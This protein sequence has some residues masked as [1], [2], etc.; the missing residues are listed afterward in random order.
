LSIELIVVL[1]IAALLILLVLGTPVGFALGFSG[2]LGLFLLDGFDVARSTLGRAPYNT[3]ARFVLTVIPMFILMG[4][5]ARHARVAEN[6]F[7]VLSWWLRRVPGGLAIA[8]IM[9]CAGFAAVTGSSLATI[10]AVGQMA[11]REMQ[12]YGYSPAVSAGVVGAAG[13][14]GVLIPP[15]IP[16]VI[17]A[18]LARE[19]IAALLLAGVIPGVIS[20]V[21]YAVAIYLRARRRPHEFGEGVDIAKTL[22]KPHLTQAI[23]GLA[24][25]SILFLVVVGGIYSGL[26]TA[27]EAAAVGAFAAIVMLLVEHR[28]QGR[29]AIFLLR[30]SIVDT[31]NLNGMVFALLIGAAVFTTFNVS[32]GLPHTFTTWIL[33]LPLDP[34]VVVLMLLLAFIPLGMFLDPISILIIG[35]PL[36]APAVSALGF[37][38]IWFGILIVK[39]IEVGLITPPLGINAYVVSSVAEGVTPEIAFRGVLWFL[40]LDLLA[41]AVIFLYPPLVT[42]LPEMALG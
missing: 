31:V 6:G 2:A 36:A 14:L 7:A 28:K 34:T 18:I 29:R 25:I 26:F 9:A 11:M 23:S 21:I 12:R 41:I 5:V 15:S 8:T 20:A 1:A 24:R 13:T 17:Y 27:I 39:M 37:D 40:P 38:G 22:V 16:L 3:S 19:S 33:G 32:A 30:D 35:V 4:V 10:V 42:F